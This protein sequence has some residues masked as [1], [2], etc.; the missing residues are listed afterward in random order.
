MRVAFRRRWRAFVA[1]RPKGS[2]AAP[3]FRTVIGRLSLLSAALR[4]GAS[5]RQCFSMVRWTENASSLGSTTSWLHPSPH[6]LLFEYLALRRRFEQVVGIVTSNPEPAI[7]PR[8]HS[9]ASASQNNRGHFGPGG[10]V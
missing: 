10:P 7:P 5:L 1:G 4:L 6:P 8:G 9:D 2:V 3:Q